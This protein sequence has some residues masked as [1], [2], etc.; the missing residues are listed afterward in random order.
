MTDYGKYAFQAV[1]FDSQVKA[2][3]FSYMTCYNYHVAD[4]SSLEHVIVT[5]HVGK[6]ECIDL[7]RTVLWSY[8]YINIDKVD[9]KYAKGKL[10]LYAGV[11]TPNDV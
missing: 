11:V 4:W 3:F 10:Y 1:F 9:K 6:K 5:R 7:T 8:L 2:P